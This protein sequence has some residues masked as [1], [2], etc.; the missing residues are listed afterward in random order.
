MSI[1]K[2]SVEVSVATLLSCLVAVWMSSSAVAQNTTPVSW[3]SADNGFNDVLGNNPGTVNGTVTFVP[4]QIGQA[5]HFA[6]S[7][8]I[9]WANNS[10]GLSPSSQVMIVA[11]IRPDFTA[12][13]EKDTI[14]TKRNG[15]GNRSYELS[16]YKVSSGLPAGTIIFATSLGTDLYSNSVVPNDGQFHQVAG[17]YDGQTMRVFLDGQ[18]VG[19][20]SLPGFIES[21]SALPT[22]GVDAGCQYSG[23][24]SQ[25]DIDEIRVFS[26]GGF[27]SNGSNTFNGNQ[28]VNGIVTATGFSGDGSSLTNLAAANIATGTANININGMAASAAT[29]NNSA[30]LNGIPGPDYARVDIGN[31]FTGNQSIAGNLSTSGNSVTA[32]TTTLGNGGTPIVGHLSATF[33]P[34]FPPFKASTC[35]TASFTVPG[36]SDGDTLA[37]GVPNARTTG[38][39]RLSTSLG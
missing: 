14:I 39:E 4:G 27:I 8:S 13:N 31:S 38:A 2:K 26:D 23:N 21:T 35:A 32:G 3:W 20:K 33:N 6:G 34:S 18:L 22:T 24:L 36:A 10:A 17:S 11:W 1:S 19:Q 29:A 5:F 30:N 7:G 28:A 15:C 16:V 37:L 12:S 25:A 9:T